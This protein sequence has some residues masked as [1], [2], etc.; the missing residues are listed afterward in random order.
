MLPRSHD[1]LGIKLPP[2]WKGV[3]PNFLC[4]HLYDMYKWMYMINWWRSQQEENLTVQSPNSRMR[5]TAPMRGPSSIFLQENMADQRRRK[6]FKSDQA[7]CMVS[8]R[9]GI[10]CRFF[11]HY[12][13][14]KMRIHYWKHE[15]ADVGFN[16]TI[17]IILKGVA[18]TLA[19]KAS[20]TNF[21][22][23]F[24]KEPLLDSAH[25]C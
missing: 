18:L 6:Q 11:L 12:D 10:N 14:V 25:G 21:K 2:F 1:R 16:L 13:W 19:S 23:L 7:M 15:R 4:S 24:M 20:N 22:L 5:S 17:I 9:R 3:V 8:S